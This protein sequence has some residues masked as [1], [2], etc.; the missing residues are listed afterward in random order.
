MHE[1]GLIVRSHHER[2][3]GGGYPDRLAG[4]TIPL[5]ARIIAC[6]DSW[7][8]MRTDRAYRKA[9]THDE[10][11]AQVQSNR[12]A[13]FDPRI[14]ETLIAIVDGAPQPRPDRT[15]SVLDAATAEHVAQLLTPP[16]QL[17]IDKL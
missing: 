2:W 7:N 9:L 15:P 13:Q 6:C 8:A 17:D 3:D 16:V 4:E 10:A 11:L 1:V 5:E 12:G 14:A